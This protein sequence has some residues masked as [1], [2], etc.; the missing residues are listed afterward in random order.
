MA[1]ETRIIIE[2]LDSIKLELDYIKKHMADVD[3]ILTEDDMESLEEAE[4]D[5]REGKTKRLA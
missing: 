1:E 3:T 4:R 5:L 2:K